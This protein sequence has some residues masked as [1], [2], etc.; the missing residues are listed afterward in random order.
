MIKSVLR[1]S[2]VSLILVFLFTI[3]GFAKD[4]DTT[5]TKKKRKGELYYSWGY[6]AEW[7]TKSNIHIQ[8]PTLGN[9]YTYEGVQGHDHPGWNQQNI[10]NEGITIPQWSMRIGY[11]FGDAKDY[12]IEL[13]YDHA[14]YIFEGQQ[15][16]LVGKLEGSPTDTSFMFKG[17]PSQALTA[18][19][20][21]YFLN[22]GANWFEGNFMKRWHVYKNKNDNFKID[23]ITKVGAGFC[24]PHVQDCLFGKPNI[25]HF[26]I[27]GFNLGTEGVLR[28]TFFKYAYLEYCNK[29]V[30][31]NYWGLRIYEGTASQAFGAYEMILN[32][33][34]TF[35]IGKRIM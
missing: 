9:D 1:S 4:G 10:F 14:K 20:N 13:N 23:V 35:P 21:Y 7:Y 22:N 29:L 11:F 15:T 5:T 6:N 30:Y 31:A 27:G 17:D 24:F 2:F 32:L 12:G 18:S 33:G 8:Q 16:H 19:N 34:V 3:N 26:Q 28:L 25:S